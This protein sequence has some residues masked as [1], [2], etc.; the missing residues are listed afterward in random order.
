MDEDRSHDPFGNIQC[1]LNIFCFRLVSAMDSGVTGIKNMARVLFSCARPLE[2][3]PLL[4]NGLRQSKKERPLTDGLP[5]GGF[6]S[7]LGIPTFCL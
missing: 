1:D 3:V 5:I 6:N 4:R 2:E 7:R